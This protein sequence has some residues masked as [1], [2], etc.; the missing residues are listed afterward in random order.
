MRCILIDEDRP[1]LE[2][3]QSHLSRIP[4]VELA[5]S[6]DD[7]FGAMD[8]LMKNPVDLVICGVEM[9]GI[10]GLQL[11]A[12]VSN[13][14]PAIF[15]SDS[16]E[17]A[18]EAFALDAVDYLLKPFPFE[19]LLRAVNKA[20]EVYAR[21]NSLP[22]PRET[23]PPTLPP[24]SGNPLFVKSENRLVRV[25]FEEILLVEGYGDY[26]KLHLSDGRVVLSLQNMGHFEAQL[27]AAKF[28]RVHRSYIVAVDKIEEIERKRIRI[29]KHLIPIS[30]SY[31][32]RFWA[33]VGS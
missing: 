33:R 23:L 28:A 15:V 31:Q 14:P 8:H 26:I 19:R 13:R 16:R 10:D 1:T 22:M 11:I 7:P 24:T 5:G 32:E 9:A 27:P 30:E 20:Y 21:Q 4:F 18:V 17:A 12:S 3:L 2:I 29:G 25:F 6:F